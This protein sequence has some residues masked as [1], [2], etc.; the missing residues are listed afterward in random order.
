MTDSIVASIY[1]TNKSYNDAME[2]TYNQLMNATTLYNYKDMSTNARVSPAQLF[3]T[4]YES[5]FI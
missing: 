2:E 5:Y 3:E 4:A 1:D